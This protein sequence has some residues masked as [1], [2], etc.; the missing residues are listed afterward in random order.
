MRLIGHVTGEVNAQLFSDYLSS[1]E[2]K[3][4]IEHDEGNK[5]AVWIY[6]EDQVDTGK[7]RLAEYLANPSDPK[8]VQGARQGEKV[9]T[10]ER[11]EEEK[12]SERVYTRDQIWK[13]TSIG[14]FTL[15]LI[16]ICV[17]CSL[18]TGFSSPAPLHALFMSEQPFRMLP[19]IEQGQVWRLI[20]P[21]FIHMGPLHLLFNMLWL[22]E[23][24]T[25]IEV[26]EGSWKF[27]MYVLIFGL[28]SNFTQF[29]W[30][31]PIFGGM[32]GVVY[33]LFGYIWMRGRF[34]PFSGYYVSPQTVYSMIVWFVLCFTPFIPGVANGAHA[35]G[36]FA[37]MI[38]G[39]LPGLLRR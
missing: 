28:I 36:L 2:I 26:H 5:W 4:S 19:E 32:S 13:N 12:L 25:F 3:S 37:G 17:G 33:A 22:R 8:Y 7:Q 38:A 10:R 30:K 27:L 23:L 16:I 20:T 11:K 18:Y 34:D 14:P 1:L 35:G 39:A 6:S 24:G 9:Q 29:Y 31:G 21:I 15:A